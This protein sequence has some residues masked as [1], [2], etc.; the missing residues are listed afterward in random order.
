MENE[1]VPA[2]QT[3][4]QSSRPV[5]Q[6]TAVA[7]A[8]GGLIATAAALGIGRF[9]YTPILPP[10]DRGSKAQQVRSGSDRL[11]KFRGLPD[12]RVARGNA[13]IARFAAPVAARVTRGQCR[14]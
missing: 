6:V 11:R 13:A 14:H 3:E 2:A 4:P 12:R 1:R 9:V 8:L 10:M 7:A 5:G